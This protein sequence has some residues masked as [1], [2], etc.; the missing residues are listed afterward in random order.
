MLQRHSGAL[1]SGS[2]SWGVVGDRIYADSGGEAFASSVLAE[3]VYLVRQMCV[4][5]CESAY[6]N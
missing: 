5:I 2:S 4:K 1:P 6:R 3:S